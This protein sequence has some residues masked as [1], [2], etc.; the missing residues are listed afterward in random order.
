MTYMTVSQ[1][2]DIE[3]DLEEILDDVDDD[4]LLEL[5]Y[6]RLNAKPANNGGGMFADPPESLLEPLRACDAANARTRLR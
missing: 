5:G 4:T 1:Y 3:I 2:V 6:R